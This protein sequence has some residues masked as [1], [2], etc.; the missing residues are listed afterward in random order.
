MAVEFILG[1]QKEMC[2]VKKNINKSQ[3]TGGKTHGN[4]ET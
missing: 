2:K 4:E 3:K 1:G